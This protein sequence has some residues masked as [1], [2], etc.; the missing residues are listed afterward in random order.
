M[1]GFDWSFPLLAGKSE[2]S[3]P[4][5]IELLH[6]GFLFCI[7]RPQPLVGAQCATMR[8]SHPGGFSFL[9]GQR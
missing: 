4:V 8:A 7:L 3:H 2:H 1:E 5:V 6:L 9:P